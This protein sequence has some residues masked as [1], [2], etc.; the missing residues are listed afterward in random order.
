LGIRDPSVNEAAIADWSNVSV[1][2]A[3]EV[4]HVIRDAMVA[5]TVAV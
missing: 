4:T 1:S 3:V 5:A 2:Q